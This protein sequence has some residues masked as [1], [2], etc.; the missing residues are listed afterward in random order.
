MKS[1]VLGVAPL[2][3]VT[4]CAA[5]AGVPAAQTPAAPMLPAAQSAQAMGAETA[6]T[7]AISDEIRKACGIA[8]EDAYF[9]FDSA[10]IQTVVPPLDAVARCFTAGPLAGRSLHLIG[11]A[12]PRGPSEYN[13][14]LG[15][16]RAD[17]VQ[18]YLA[19]HGLP[20]A[21]VGTTSRGALDATG[22]DELGWAHDRRVDVVLGS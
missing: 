22:Q 12:D 11:H 2:F 17:S 20:P 6:G 18:S 16:A 19:L 13:M 21:E 3:L 14:T 10:R 9:P 7:V 15:E 5:K 8:D 4:A 1:L